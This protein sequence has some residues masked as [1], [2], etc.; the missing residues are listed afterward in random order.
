M[1]HAMRQFLTGSWCWGLVL[2][3]AAGQGTADDAGSAV[4]TPA[5]MDAVQAQVNHVLHV[6]GEPGDVELGRGRILW[7]TGN[8]NKWTTRNFERILRWVAEGNVCW[9]DTGLVSRLGLVCGFGGS[10]RVALVTEDAANHPLAS[11]VNQ[12]EAQDTFLY[13][14]GLPEGAQAVLSAWNRAD[15]VVVAAWPVGNGLVLIRPARKPN[16][17]EANSRA[18][19]HWIEPCVADGRRLLH[20]INLRSLEVIGANFPR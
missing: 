17:V 5:E 7:L 10:V 9:I 18:E 12:I 13:M 20:N 14:R 3:L 19:R 16:I 8:E 4:P 15:H 1:Q 2:I 6:A 11:G